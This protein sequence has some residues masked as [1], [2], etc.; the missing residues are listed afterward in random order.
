MVKSQCLD[1]EIISPLSFCPDISSLSNIFHISKAWRMDKHGQYVLELFLCFQPT[2]CGA[3]ARQV[4]VSG[5]KKRK[6]HG[7]KL[8]F[9]ILFYLCCFSFPYLFESPTFPHVSFSPSNSQVYFSTMQVY[10]SNLAEPSLPLSP[11]G[12]MTH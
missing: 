12:R 4:G 1:R 5:K 11:A 7:S 3:V 10:C 9:P 2:E 8:F 6:T